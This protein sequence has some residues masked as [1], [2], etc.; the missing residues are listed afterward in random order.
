M[1]RH[2]NRNY[3]PCFTMLKTKYTMNKCIKHYS[4]KQ[5]VLTYYQVTADILDRFTMGKYKRE[6]SDKCHRLV[7]KRIEKVGKCNTLRK[8][9]RVDRKCPYALLYCTYNLCRIIKED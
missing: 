5:S 3:N 6:Q 4:R 9:E 8:K 1:L 2:A 7:V